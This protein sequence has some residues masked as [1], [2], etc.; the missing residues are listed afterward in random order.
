ML[1]L[2]SRCDGGGEGALRKED[3]ARTFRDEVR[4]LKVQMGSNKAGCAVFVEGGQNGVIRLP[5]GCGGWGWQRFVDELRSMVVHLDGKALPVVLDVINKEVGCAANAG[6]VVCASCSK[7]SAMEAQ[8][9]K[10]VLGSNLWPSPDV[11]MEAVRCVAKDF[12]AKVRVEVD[13]VL[14]F[15]LGL[16][17]DAS[18][19]IKRRMGRVLS[20]LGLKP[21]LLFDLKWR[22]RRRPL[23]VVSRFKTKADGVRVPNSSSW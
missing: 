20:R 11:M 22:G 3:F 15:G 17:A 4:M 5:E 12:L 14:F 13:R 23:V 19:D 8:A 7:S 6:V 1:G 9:H 16:K 10:Y 18:C 2:A 21:K